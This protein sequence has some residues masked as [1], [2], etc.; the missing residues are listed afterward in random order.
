LPLS[1]A[2]IGLKS[3]SSPCREFIPSRDVNLYLKTTYAK[4]LAR[5]ILLFP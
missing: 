1:A 5:A 3:A 2:P 4:K